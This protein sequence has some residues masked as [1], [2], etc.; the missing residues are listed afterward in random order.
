MLHTTNIQMV[1]LLVKV[2]NLDLV[3]KQK[4][5]IL[6]ILIEELLQL[7]PGEENQTYFYP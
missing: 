4:I 1:S 6:S 7:K 3:T 2:P 5:L